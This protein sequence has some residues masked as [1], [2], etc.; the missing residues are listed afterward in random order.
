MNCKNCN[1]EINSKFCP[2]CGQPTTLKR[3]DGKYIIH[4]IE[5]VLHFERG[6]FFTIKELLAK[7]SQTIRKFITEDRSRLVKPVIFIIVTSLIYTIIEHLFHTK[8]TYLYF[9][10][11]ENSVMAQISK[12]MQGHYGY[13]N[14]MVGITI[15]FWLKILFKKYG[16]N[17]FEILIVLCYVIGV[18]M[19]IFS[20]FALTEGITH[21]KFMKI[22]GIF[23][24]IYLVWTVGSFFGNKVI[25]YVKALLSYI[26]GSLTLVS[27]IYILGWSIEKI[28]NK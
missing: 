6:I 17:Y 27:I 12:W 15:A 5:H 16:F 13:A 3:I 19:L 9:E 8:F 20:I 4:E 2:D 18:Q 14:I 26:L 28:L 1:T 25:N 24:M 23:G 7:P 22:A 11:N 21:F 10:G